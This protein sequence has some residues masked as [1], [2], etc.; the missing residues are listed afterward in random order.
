MAYESRTDLEEKFRGLSARND[1]QRNKLEYKEMNY[2][3]KTWAKA[4]KVLQN[5][6][7]IPLSEFAG[8]FQI[9]LTG[10]RDLIQD[11]VEIHKI[12]R[13]AD[14][15]KKYKKDYARDRRIPNRPLDDKYSSKS[16]ASQNTKFINSNYQ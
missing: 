7:N 9:H 10:A 5:N 13:D 3:V 11:I 14:R 12:E 2:G 16:A 6:P 4:V 8:L 1:T 15:P